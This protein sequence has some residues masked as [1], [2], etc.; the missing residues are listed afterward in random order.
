M[1]KSS[2]TGFTL[3]EL[4]IVIAII[5]LLATLSVIALSNARTKANDAIKIA[6][7]KAIS[8]ALQLLYDKTGKL[9]LNY[10]GGGACSP[11]PEYDQSMQELVTA[12]FLKKIPR[13]PANFTA[14]NGYC[15][16]NYGSG[17]NIGGLVVTNLQTPPASSTGEPPS[18]RPFA[19]ATNWCDQSVTRYY[20]IC[21]PFQ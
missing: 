4:L 17:N 21:N 9:P 3:I 12:G 6:D 16:Y 5:G 20:C 15:Y 11:T 13:P 8:T 14:A 19:A 10:G 2:R 1:S 7:L 18:C